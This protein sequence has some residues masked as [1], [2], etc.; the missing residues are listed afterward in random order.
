[1]AVFRC[2]MC[3]GTLDI[4]TGTTVATCEYCGTK[5]TLPKLDD[6]HK[7][8]LYDRANHFR[9]NNEFDKAMGIYEQILN[10]D[11]TDAE[12]YWSIVL[13]RFGIEYVEDSYTHKR[14]PT[15]NRAQFTSVFDDNNY[16]SAL[17]YADDVQRSIYEEE[18]KTINEIQKGILAIS[19]REEP[20][21]VFIC[22][23]ETDDKGRRTPDSVLATELYHQ[24]NNE[25][26]KVFF[27][28]ITLEDKL[29][30]AYEPYIF[31]ALNSAKVM[32]VIGTKPEF[33][34]AAWVRNEW[35]R[36]LALIKNGAQKVLIPAYRDMDPYDLP[37]E[38]SHLQ[39]Q[40]MSKLGFMQDLIRGIEKL[41]RSAKPNYNQESTVQG[42]GNIAPL[43]R[44]VYL[45][46]ED[47]DWENANDYCEKVLDLDPENGEAYLGK[48]MVELRVRRRENL[49]DLK[50]SFEQNLFYKKVVRF[51]D[52][53]LVEELNGYIKAIGQKSERARL[54]S[55]YNDGDK[56]MASAK[57]EEDYLRAAEIF[58]SINGFKDADVKAKECRN[59]ANEV[60]FGGLYASACALMNAAKT[61]ADFLK[62]SKAFEAIKEYK[63]AGKLALACEK[64]AD[65][66]GK[67]AVYA[68]ALALM[69]G[70]KAKNYKQAIVAFEKIP[71]WKDSAQKIE[72]CNNKIAEIN[73]GIAAATIEKQ[74]R[75][76]ARKESIKE[77]IPMV[78]KIS[79]I[80]APVLVLAIIVTTLVPKID[81]SQFIPKDNDVSTESRPNTSTLPETSVFPEA[82]YQPETS[83]LRETSESLENSEFPDTSES[84]ENSKPLE[85]SKPPESSERP[86]QTPPTTEPPATTDI[87]HDDGCFF[88][89]GDPTDS[90]SKEKGEFICC[91]PHPTTDADGNVI[92]IDLYHHIRMFE[93]REYHYY[94]N[95]D[96]VLARLSYSTSN[97]HEYYYEYYSNGNVEYYREW[98]SNGE[99]IYTADYDID[100]TIRYEEKNGIT[101]E[102]RY[103]NG[104]VVAKKTS[105]KDASGNDI[106]EL[107][108]YNAA[109]I[110][111]SKREKTNNS[112]YDPIKGY[113]Y[114]YDENGKLLYYV[115][116]DF[117]S[118]KE[119]TITFYNPQVT[120][121][122]KTYC[123]AFNSF[124]YTCDATGMYFDNW[125]SDECIYEVRDSLGNSIAQVF[126]GSSGPGMSPST[127]YYKYDSKGNVITRQETL[128]SANYV[129]QIL[130]TTYN[131]DGEMVKQE[132]Y[133]CDASYNMN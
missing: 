50:E 2:K 110:V 67:D 30:T 31:A 1:M 48:M 74:Q 98:D 111:V 121:I 5:Q 128:Y 24:L 130:Q 99:V 119:F 81:F 15:V 16:K 109:G 14:I 4:T 80:V 70:N 75:A 125:S 82:S 63:D 95:S 42:G 3:G 18:A 51:G 34:N 29:G 73:A 104:K 116:H 123:D 107:Y 53:R 12:A 68:T 108:Q 87:V 58:S 20:F 129:G 126:V 69:V 39:A 22:Y 105:R 6:E 118:T 45:F 27:S 44:R 124:A 9:R 65:I 28:R 72:F 46:L 23:K 100:G 76:E 36:F 79:L 60:H 115:V 54:V 66:A 94:Y 120:I 59:L 21:D 122:C 92:K 8:N 33:F 7:S 13:C 90:L 35:S 55:A 88:N 62:A 38:F 86:I 112:A 96:R 25:G 89:N 26:F 43:L 64:K 113:E 56:Q 97:G 102:Y 10:E 57:T 40:D 83:E 93:N 117:Q 77:K 61:E 84:L 19:Q 131:S 106:E 37:E 32:V 103:E 52:D 91:T 78:K 11:N 85:T 133:R 132:D 71:G 114:Q 49:E 101:T 47:A 41:T 127:V 17:K